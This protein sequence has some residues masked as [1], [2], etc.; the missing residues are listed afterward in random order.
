LAAEL[1]GVLGLGDEAEEDLGEEHVGVKR[2]PYASCPTCLF[3][4]DAARVGVEGSNP[5]ARSKCH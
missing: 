2:G 1:R 3:S 5:F 4:L